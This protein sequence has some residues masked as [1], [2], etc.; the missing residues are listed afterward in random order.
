[1]ISQSWIETQVVSLPLKELKQKL[2]VVRL[3]M[4]RPEIAN[5]LGVLLEHQTTMLNIKAIHARGGTGV[6][7]P[8]FLK[9]LA[10]VARLA[11]WLF[12]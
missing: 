10:R 8:G 12:G 6:G 3:V 11:P 2:G 4:T 9:R 7:Y 1:M 5:L